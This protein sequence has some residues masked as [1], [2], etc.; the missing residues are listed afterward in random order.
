M[1]EDS[2]RGRN[3]KMGVSKDAELAALEHKQRREAAAN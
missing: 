2:K 3:V 1:M